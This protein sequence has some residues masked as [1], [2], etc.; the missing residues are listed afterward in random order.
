M[1]IDLIALLKKVEAANLFFFILLRNF[2][3]K[4]QIVPQEQFDKKNLLLHKFDF[5]LTRNDSKTLKLIW[6]RT[7]FCQ[8]GS[9]LIC[10]VMKRHKCG[11]F[12]VYSE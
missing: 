11:H 2:Y 8:F 7:S 4:S 6:T 12:N 10:G 3:E 5:N 9:F 1:L